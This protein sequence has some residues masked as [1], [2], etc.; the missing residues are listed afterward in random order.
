MEMHWKT[1]LDCIDRA[2]KC[3]QIIRRSV[4]LLEQ[5]HLATI[6]ERT[7]VSWIYRSMLPA[8]FAES[9]KDT[10]LSRSSDRRGG[11]FV[12][13]QKTPKPSV[14]KTFAP[15]VCGHENLKKQFLVACDA[16]VTC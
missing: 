1:K 10:F 2:H 16:A 13:A 7:Q 15:S 12:F 9:T 4:E 14:S 3:T 11:I 6:G 8:Q 5:V